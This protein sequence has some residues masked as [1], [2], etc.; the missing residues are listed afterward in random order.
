[1][2]SSEQNTAGVHII[3]AA[4]NKTFRNGI[5]AKHHHIFFSRLWRIRPFYDRSRRPKKWITNPKTPL[6]L[7]GRNSHA[8]RQ[9]LHN[10]HARGTHSLVITICSIPTAIAACR[11]LPTSLRLLALRPTWQLHGP[12]LFRDHHYE[13]IWL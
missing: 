10:S 2:R 12:G 1:M 7:S 6:V 9:Q 11:R 8:H 5:S 4:T 13:Q 3:S